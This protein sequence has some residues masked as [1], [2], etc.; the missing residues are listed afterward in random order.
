MN[1]RQVH[2]TFQLLRL[3]YLFIWWCETT[4]GFIDSL[5]DV[6]VSNFFSVAMGLIIFI[7]LG[8]AL[9]LLTSVFTYFYIDIYNK[10]GTPYLKPLKNQ[11]RRAALGRP[12]IKLLWGGGGLHLVCRRQTLVLNSALVPQTLSCSICV[13]NS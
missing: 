12:A 10:N 7:L 4:E 1:V 13:E 2:I 3:C 11:N 8:I 6:K 9:P 5:F